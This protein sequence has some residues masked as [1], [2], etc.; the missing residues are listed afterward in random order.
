MLLQIS[1]T[2]CCRSSALSRFGKY[3]KDRIEEIRRPEVHGTEMDFLRKKRELLKALTPEQ[4]LSMIE[5]HE[6]LTLIEA[7]EKAKREAKVIVPNIVIDRILKRRHCI[8]FNM[9]IT[10]T[11]C[12]YEATGV[13]FKSVVEHYPYSGKLGWVYEVPHEFIG[14]KDAIL[15]AE[16]PD[17][18]FRR[19]GHLI[20]LESEKMT[21]IR[22]FRNFD[23]GKSYRT[24]MHWHIP[25]PVF[26]IPVGPYA[27][28]SDSSARRLV[29]DS[30]GLCFVGM[31]I[32]YS[33]AGGWK[34]WQDVDLEYSADVPFMVAMF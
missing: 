13:Q 32:R 17:F 18:T 22:D 33:N 21:L 30:Q 16:H 6:E 20:K 5:I 28:S 29:L 25:D 9:G 4:A 1:P 23:S 8:E 34:K 7:L 15:V 24:R 2:A 3:K 31:A 19:S 14:V 11:A 10:G 27:S 12:V 26:G